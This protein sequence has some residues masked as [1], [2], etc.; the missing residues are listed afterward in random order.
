M[1]GFDH[2]FCASWRDDNGGPPASPAEA[3]AIYDAVR[4]AWPGA[5][6]VASTLEDYAA[7][8]LAAAPGLDLPVVTG[9][10]G[11]VTRR[12][13]AGRPLTELALHPPL[14]CLCTHPSACVRLQLR[15]APR[16]APAHTGV[17]V[18]PAGGEGGKRRLPDVL[19][20]PQSPPRR[21]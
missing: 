20:P 2:V 11:V 18:G 4:R 21:R 7:A 5:R 19:A 8:L 9:G 14:P 17:A 1:Q 15:A 10:H 3:R 12:M 13:P 6:V 16:Q